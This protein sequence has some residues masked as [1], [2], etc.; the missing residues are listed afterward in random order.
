MRLNGDYCF[1]VD[2][3][4]FA[5]RADLILHVARFDDNGRLIPE[6]RRG[7][8]AIL[9]RNHESSFVD[10]WNSYQKTITFNDSDY[11]LFIQAAS[12]FDNSIAISNLKLE[13]GPCED[14]G[15]KFCDFDGQVYNEDQD[16]CDWLEFVTN[17][18]NPTKTWRTRNVWPWSY[19]NKDFTT[20]SQDGSFLRGAHP[21]HVNDTMILRIRDVFK[22][23]DGAHCFIF[24]QNTLGDS[25]FQVIEQAVGSNVTHVLFEPT[26]AETYWN[27]QRRM[28]DIDPILPIIIT[29]RLQPHTTYENH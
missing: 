21:E 6:N 22:P 20:R 29:L 27:W 23:E 17:V 28:V 13:E 1:S 9:V 25:R 10:K 15:E 12:Q 8:T 18:D 4:V 24:Y 2:Y 16:A 3:Y 5:F 14:N 11:K 7:K 19:P 26:Q